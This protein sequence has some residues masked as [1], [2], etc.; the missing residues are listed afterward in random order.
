M[1]RRSIY[2]ENARLPSKNVVK[3]LVYLRGYAEVSVC[4]RVSIR[5]IKDWIGK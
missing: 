3:D 2:N 1:R 5:T 4:Y